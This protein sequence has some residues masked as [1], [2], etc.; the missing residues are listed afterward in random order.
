MLG[1]ALAQTGLSAVVGQSVRS[2][3]SRSVQLEDGQELL[4]DLV[5]VAAGVRPEVS[6][7]REAGIETRRGILVDDE[8]ATS[9]PG[10]LGRRRVC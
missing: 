7:A 8:M 2:I 3:R 4:A 10:R 9:A 1:R 6:L 5:V